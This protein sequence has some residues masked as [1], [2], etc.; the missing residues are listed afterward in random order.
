MKCR[1]GSRCSM[2]KRPVRRRGNP[3]A[4]PAFLCIMLAVLLLGL[5]CLGGEPAFEALLT[6]LA[7]SEGFVS[8]A[9]AL[10]LGAG[11][12]PVVHT[13]A[14][15]GSGLSQP[16][17]PDKA[18]APPEPANE[19]AFAAPEIPAGAF[20]EKAATVE[21]SGTTGLSF[22]V[23]EML[24]NPLEL[25]KTDGPQVLIV[26]THGTEA[27][28]NDENYSYTSEEN[29]RTTDTQ[30]NVVAVGD[31]LAEVLE[32]HGIQTIHC[33]SMFDH[34]SYNGSYGRSLEEIKAQ[35]AANPSIQV[36]IDLHRDDIS[37]E[38]GG[39]MSLDW[40]QDGEE[41]ARMMFVIGSGESGLTHENWEQNLNWAVNLQAKLDAAYPGLMRAVN[42]RKQRF[43]QH[44]R[45]GSM[46]I[47][48]GASGNTLTQA[49]RSI[50]LFGGFLA[51][52]LNA[53]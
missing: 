6:R 47:E 24:A 18:P 15:A 9:L 31:R 7:T 41:Y 45:P 49:L 13:P 37:L 23:E 28:T 10:E 27:Y 42:L 29:F 46:I 30:Y 21:V 39:K 11:G 50:E 17:E 53:A 19:S 35:L 51:A 33:R 36:V 34:P 26:H 40:E 12:R 2:K 44:L 14:T 20:S 8:G 52:E 22:D 16:P 48:C 38:G 3:I 25:R 43:N 32:S 1:K 4:L 5:H